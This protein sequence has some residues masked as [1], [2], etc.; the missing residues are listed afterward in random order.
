MNAYHGSNESAYIYFTGQTLVNFTR[1]SRQ[2][3]LIDFLPC[4]DKLILPPLKEMGPCW[5]DHIIWE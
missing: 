1:N 2:K 3:G 5:D 4:N